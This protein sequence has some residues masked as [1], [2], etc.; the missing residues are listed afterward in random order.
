MA[1][2]GHMLVLI[3]PKIAVLFFIGYPLEYGN[4]NAL[5]NCV[6]HAGN[7]IKWLLNSFKLDDFTSFHQ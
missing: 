5:V 2:H 7:D 6:I 1:S 4:K 3:P